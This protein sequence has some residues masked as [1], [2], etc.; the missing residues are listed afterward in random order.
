MQTWILFY[1]ETDSWPTCDIYHPDI[2]YWKTLKP[3]N[4]ILLNSLIVLSILNFLKGTSKEKD[5]GEH[6]IKCEPPMCKCSSTCS[7]GFIHSKTISEH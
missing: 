1:N 3:W 6:Q 4:C 2:K 5:Y 7:Q